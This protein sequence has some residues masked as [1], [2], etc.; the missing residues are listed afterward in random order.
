MRLRSESKSYTT[1]GSKA[2]I[3]VKLDADRDAAIP[4]ALREMFD[5]G[6]EDDFE[7]HHALFGGCL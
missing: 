6:E 2:Y 1:Q 3:R 7:T 4:S 5:D